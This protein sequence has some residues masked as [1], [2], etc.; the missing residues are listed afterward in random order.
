LPPAS[1]LGIDMIGRLPSNDLHAITVRIGQI[2]GINHRITAVWS[3][4][5]EAP[6]AAKVHVD[7]Y[8]LYFTKRKNSSWELTNAGLMSRDPPKLW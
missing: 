5:D 4:W 2:P 7:N 3:V 6:V 1:K 8:V